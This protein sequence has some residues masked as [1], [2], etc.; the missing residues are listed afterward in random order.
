MTARVLE[1][2]RSGF[3]DL[4]F[5]YRHPLDSMLTNWFYWCR[6][7]PSK[8]PFFV[9]EGYKGT[10]AL[11]ADLERGFGEFKAFA[12][13]DPRVFPQGGGARFLSFREFVEETEQFLQSATLSLRLEDFMVDPVKEFSKI[14]EVMSADLDLSR[15]RLAAPTTKPYRYLTVKE[16]VAP[17]REFINELDAETKARIVKMGYEL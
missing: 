4:I 8:L 17:F 9:S 3:A 5:S 10:D 11:C 6:G 14:V 2:V 15:L 12:A 1:A 7:N 16:N 13:G